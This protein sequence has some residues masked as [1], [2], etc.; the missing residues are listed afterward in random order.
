M[1]ARRSQVVVGCSLSCTKNF[2]P[3]RALGVSKETMTF[4]G[5][6]LR[7]LTAAVTADASEK[8]ADKAW[9]DVGVMLGPLTGSCSHC[10]AKSAGHREFWGVPGPP[11]LLHPSGKG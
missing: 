6:S 5:R 7:G 1:G 10:L 4:C 2:E 11:L 8:A 3:G 9:G